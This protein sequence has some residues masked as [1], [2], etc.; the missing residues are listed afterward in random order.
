MK[1]V[2]IRPVPIQVSRIL[3]VCIVAVAGLR[4]PKFGFTN[5]F[6]IYV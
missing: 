3:P 2:V 5:R 4:Q 6:E 1:I